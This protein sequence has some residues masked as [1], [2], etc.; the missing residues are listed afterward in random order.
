[1]YSLPQY[2]EYLKNY[3]AHYQMDEN[4]YKAK[5]LTHLKLHH[6]SP[7]FKTQAY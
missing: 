3:Y 1:M 2:Q 6:T 5:I 4:S 7:T